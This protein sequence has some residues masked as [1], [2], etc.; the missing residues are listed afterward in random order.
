M[1]Q[2]RNRTVLKETGSEVAARIERGELEEAYALLPPILAQR[3]PF[4][5]LELIGQAVGQC[6][7]P[8]VLPLLEHIAADRTEGGWV[9]IGSALRQLLVRDLPLSLERCRSFITIADIWYGSDILAERVPGPALVT[10][11]EVAL[12]C[13][14]PWMADENRWV[15]RAA[16]VAVH[17]WA[18]R[19][20]GALELTGQAQRLLESLEPLLEERN[21]DAV[22]GIGWGLKTLGRYYPAI[23][24]RWLEEQVVR[25]QRRCRRLMLRKALTYL[26]ES[27][28]QRLATANGTA[29]D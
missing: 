9:V 15:R 23:T 7:A 24:G 28:R 4:P 21:T 12:R 16:G 20:R 1:D 8:V 6:P 13:L 17:F 10:R 19:S 11:F 26:P 22:K 29:C 5:S 3:N 25:R 18:K 14:V 27:L 2:D